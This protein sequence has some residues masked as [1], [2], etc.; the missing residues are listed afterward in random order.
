MIINFQSGAELTVSPTQKNT[1]ALN[2]ISLFGMMI[3]DE[4]QRLGLNLSDNNEVLKWTYKH[5]REISDTIYHA[6][7][8]EGV[9]GN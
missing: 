4:I 3:C 6:L 2:E 5:L 8:E 9:Y 1:T 7:D